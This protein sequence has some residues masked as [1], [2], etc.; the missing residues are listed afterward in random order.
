MNIYIIYRNG[1]VGVY[2][3]YKSGSLQHTDGV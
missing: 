3:S 2:V 1:N